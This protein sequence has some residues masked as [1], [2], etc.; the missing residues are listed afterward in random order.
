MHTVFPAVAV[1]S[2]LVSCA[3]ASQHSGTPE[4]ASAAQVT[5]ATFLLREI[6]SNPGGL[7]AVC[8]T[9]EADS[10]STEPP[11]PMVGSLRVLGRD[12]C[13]EV[14]AQLRERATGELAM[15]VFVKS[16]EFTGSSVARVDVFTSSGAYDIAVYACALKWSE[17]AWKVDDCVLEAI[18]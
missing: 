4:R 9:Y 10:S 7:R 17:S 3:C 15:T 6:A 18:S 12:G 16:P 1:L 5:A 2:G 14:D 11:A 8:V 13:E